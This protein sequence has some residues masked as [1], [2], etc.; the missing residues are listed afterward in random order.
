M[1]HRTEGDKVDCDA[2][3][4]VLVNGRLDNCAVASVHVSTVPWHGSGWRL[5][6]FGNEGTLTAS[7]TQMVQYT[8]MKIYSGKHDGPMEEVQTPDKHRWA[9]DDTPAGEPYNVAQ[10]YRRYSQAK[11]AGEG[12]ENDFSLALRRHRLLDA[13][14]ESSDKGASVNVDI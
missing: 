14:Q 6:V 3:D 4:N 12:V 7:G 13:L 8:D 10:L 1:D 9:P 11:Q 5:E 2:P